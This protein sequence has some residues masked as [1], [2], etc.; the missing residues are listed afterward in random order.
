MSECAQLCSSSQA[1]TCRP[2]PSEKSCFFSQSMGNFTCCVWFPPLL[3]LLPSEWKS[4]SSS[5]GFCASVSTEGGICGLLGV[6]MHCV[7][8]KATLSTPFLTAAFQFSFLRTLITESM[9]HPQGFLPEQ[10][11]FQTDHFCHCYDSRRTHSA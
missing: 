6:Y 8:V 5:A 4:R 1:A 10:E 9:I 7:P 2:S 3:E 11:K